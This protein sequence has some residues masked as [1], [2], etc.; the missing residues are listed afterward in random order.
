MSDYIEKLT[1]PLDQSW[2]HFASLRA[3]LAWLVCAGA[4]IR[5]RGAKLAQVTEQHF[6]T[7]A[8]SYF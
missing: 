8:K 5:A 2:K 6:R 4:D 3:K 1:F 7:D